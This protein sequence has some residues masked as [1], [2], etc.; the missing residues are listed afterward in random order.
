M[1]VFWL[2]RLQIAAVKYQSDHP[3]EGFPTAEKFT[4]VLLH[5]PELM[6]SGS[7]REYYS[8]DLLFTPDAKENWRLPDLKPLVS[9][10]GIKKEASTY[11]TTDS[12]NLDLVLRMALT[13][14]QKT[15]ESRA[16]RG[17]IVKR[18]LG[19]FQSLVTRLRAQDSSIQ[20]YSETQAYFWIQITHAAIASM[21][22]GKVQGSESEKVAW[23]GSVSDL[24][25]GTFKTLFGITGQ[26][27]A[28]YYSSARWESVPARMEFVN[29][30][31]K[32]LPNVIS[33]PSQ[34]NVSHAKNHI[35]ETSVAVDDKEPQ[36]SSAAELTA[37]VSVMIEEV[38][39]LP[40][41]PSSPLVS[42]H[43][44]VLSRLYKI[45]ICSDE[46]RGLQSKQASA[47]IEA[48]AELRGPLLDGVTQRVFWIQ[49][50]LS[51]KETVPSVIPFAEFLKANPTL[52]NERLPYAYYSPE[53]WGSTEA[54]ETLML[55][56]R[57]DVSAGRNVPV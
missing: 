50:F 34:S 27:W 12:Y 5:S 21:Q 38:A 2:I 1:T 55:P 4:D 49:Q 23:N 15:V 37:M 43:A 51:A 36:P 47:A 28:E 31:F 45:V 9:V 24:T 10:A 32:N 54:K 56:D 44:E 46:E 8:K 13:V 48:A 25:L 42:T 29:P 7:W 57:R 20:P 41:S 39:S 22:H 16:R 3:R 30:D 17:A 14:V 33:I 6:N 52:A 53:L 40:D 26:E 18:A 19:D 11:L 35:L